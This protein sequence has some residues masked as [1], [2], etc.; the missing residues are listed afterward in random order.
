VFLVL[1]GH[2]I[3]RSRPL[4]DLVAGQK[5]KLRLF[6]LPPYAPELKP[7]EQVRNFVKH[8]GVSKAALRGASGFRRFVLVCLRSPQRLPWTLRMFLLTPNT[9][10]VAI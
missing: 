10:Y 8:Q 3:H 1:D 6:F 2:S 4:R 9:Q 7:D 5:G